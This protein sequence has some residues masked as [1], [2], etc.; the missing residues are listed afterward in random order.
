MIAMQSDPVQITGPVTGAEERILTPQAIRFLVKLSTNFESSVR[1]LYFVGPASVYSF[2]PL[3]R[4]A[5]GARF[6]A[7]RL[8]RHLS[9]AVNAGRTRV[10]VPSVREADSR[11]A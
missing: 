9:A 4:F 11:N 6:S 5:F 2:G 10:V 3:A 7:I 8:S 1:G